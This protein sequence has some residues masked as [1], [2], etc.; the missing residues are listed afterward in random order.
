MLTRVA[1][2]IVLHEKQ[3]FFGAVAGVALAAR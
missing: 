2:R 3:K 1:L